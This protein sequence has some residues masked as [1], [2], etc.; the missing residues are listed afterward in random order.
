[1]AWKS[2]EVMPL[3][4]TGR[5]FTPSSSV[6]PL[7]KHLESIEEL[8]VKGSPFSFTPVSWRWVSFCLLILGLEITRSNVRRLKES[9]L[10]KMYL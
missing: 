4:D 10:P 6:V 7:V 5:L 2:T 1:M 8:W 9:V 3:S